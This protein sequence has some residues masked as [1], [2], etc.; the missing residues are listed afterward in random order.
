MVL[1]WKGGN[2]AWSFQEGAPAQADDV[3]LIEDIVA[4]L[5]K[6]GLVDHRRIYA[7]GAS[8]GGLMAYRLARES[9][10]F[11]AIAP[12]KCGMAIGAHEPLKSTDP[13]SIMQVIGDVDKSFNGSNKTH[14]MY[15]AEERI[16]IWS[17]FNDLRKP[18]LYPIMVIGR[19][20]IMPARITK[21][22]N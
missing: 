6:Q 16:D 19:Q 7:T 11:A 18:N 17:K 3:G 2:A 5:D 1:K 12:T 14:P 9:T 10:L 21:R 8:S 4:L 15:S 20:P 22:S 13:I